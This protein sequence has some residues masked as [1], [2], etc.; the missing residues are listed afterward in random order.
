MN[1]TLLAVLML[2]QAPS[3]AQPPAAPAGQA[4]APAQPQ[5]APP[6]PPDPYSYNPD[7][8]AIRS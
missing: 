4:A 5:A 7:G 8:G 3:Q 2:L 6:V 1:A